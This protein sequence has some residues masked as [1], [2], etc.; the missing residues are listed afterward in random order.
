MIDRGEED[1]DFVW[2]CFIVSL[3]LPRVMWEEGTSVDCLDQI[4]LWPC[5]C[6][7]TLINNG[8]GRAQPTVAGTIYM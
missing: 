1:Y 6:G 3:I 8:W 4:V 5:Q 7:I 2:V